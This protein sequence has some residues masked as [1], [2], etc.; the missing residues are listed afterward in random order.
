MQWYDS[1]DMIWGNRFWIRWTIGLEKRIINVAHVIFLRDAAHKAWLR[2]VLVKGGHFS[3]LYLQHWHETHDLD[4]YK[5]N[6]STLVR[7]LHNSKCTDISLWFST[8]KGCKIV[9]SLLGVNPIKDKCTNERQGSSSKTGTLYLL[10]IVA[11]WE[12]Y[13]FFFF[14]FCWEEN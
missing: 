2:K 13:S 11:S 14:F 12:Q 6:T 4:G 5:P 7:L 8:Q 3:A 9:V 10:E 1:I